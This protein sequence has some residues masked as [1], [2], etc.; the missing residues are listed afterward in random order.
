[1][2]EKFFLPWEEIVG[3]E[4][5]VSRLRSLARS[6]RLP[7]AMLFRGMKGVGK[8]AVART[9]AASLLCKDNNDKP[10]MDCESCKVFANG[11]H[12]DYSEILP[13]GNVLKTIKIDVVR[14]MQ[15]VVSKI[16]TLSDKKVVVIDDA[17]KM[18]EAAENSLLKTLE[19]PGNVFFILVTAERSALLDTIVSRCMDVPFGGIGYKQLA[20]AI[21][22]RNVPKAEASELAS[23]SGGSLGYA[24]SLHENGGL[25]FR[26]EALSWLMRLPSFRCID[27]FDEAGKL[28]KASREELSERLAQLGTLLRDILAIREGAEN[29]ILYNKDVSAQ[30]SSLPYDKE[31]AVALLVLLADAQHRLQASVNQRLLLEGFFFRAMRV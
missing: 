15:A 11:V 30:L 13:E 5:T 23:L 16:P 4:K 10:C 9:L 6:N 17:D 20:S 27:A 1:M 19:E 2:P 12:P 18:T 28:E 3:N 21:E 7:H 29:C 26:N 8:M 22:N 25:A 31:K 24:I 14:E